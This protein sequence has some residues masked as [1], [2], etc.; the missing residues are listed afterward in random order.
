MW[1]K[2]SLRE[3]HVLLLKPSSMLIH[4]TFHACLNLIFSNSGLIGSILQGGF[5]LDMG[6]H[7]IAGLRMVSF[8]VDLIYTKLLSG[9]TS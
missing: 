8:F 5:I 9:R 1:P 6:V 7:F 4:L 3:L 2:L